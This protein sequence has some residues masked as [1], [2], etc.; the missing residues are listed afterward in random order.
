MIVPDGECKGCWYFS[1]PNTRICC[2]EGSDYYNRRVWPDMVCQL[3]QDAVD[4]LNGDLEEHHCSEKDY[5]ELELEQ[6]NGE[7]DL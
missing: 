4:P 6:G 2:C 7:R 1:D 5:C 3:F